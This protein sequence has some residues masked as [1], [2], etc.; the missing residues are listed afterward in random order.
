L[1]GFFVITDDIGRFTSMVIVGDYEPTRT[2]RSKTRV[3]STIA[4]DLD[5]AG[6]AFLQATGFKRKSSGGR[7]KA[8]KKTSK[9]L[10]VRPGS[11]LK[12]LA[13]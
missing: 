5:A 6:H 12:N 9:N 10:H 7:K 8:D 2:F 3:Q 13:V 1:A 4:L 11:F